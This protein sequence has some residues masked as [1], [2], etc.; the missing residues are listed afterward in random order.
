MRTRPSARTGGPYSSTTTGTPPSTLGT[1][2]STGSANLASTNTVIG[3][4]LTGC[5][6]TLGR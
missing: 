2:R 4:S 1:L 3:H 5:P 6:L